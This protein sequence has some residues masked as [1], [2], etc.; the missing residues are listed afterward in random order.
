MR[1]VEL[2][3]SAMQQATR[4]QHRAVWTSDRIERK[5]VRPRLT[6][7]GD[8]EMDRVARAF[9]IEACA[10]ADNAENSRFLFVAVCGC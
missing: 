2:L 5:V 7:I 3:V 4:S 10:S 8:R 1:R 9:V 6:S